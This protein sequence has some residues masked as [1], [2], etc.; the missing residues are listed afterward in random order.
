VSALRQSDLDAALGFLREAEDVTGPTAFP[1]ELLERLEELVPADVVHFC[2]LDRVRQRGI[3]DTFGAGAGSF[4]EVEKADPGWYWRVR[5]EHPT[6]WHQEQ[7]GDFSARKVSDFVTLRELRRREIY[8]NRFRYWPFELTVGLPAPPWHT[9]VFLFH[10]VRHDFR[11]RE[12]ELLELLR[13][14]LVHLWESAKVRRTADAL[15]AGAEVQGELVVFDSGHAIEFATTTA[16]RLLGEYFDGARGARLPPAVEDWLRDE[17]RPR[18]PLL[19]G[20]GQRRLV[21]GRLGGDMSALVL[22]EEAVT[23]AKPLSFREWQVVEL[24]EEG[25]SNA[26]IAAVLWISP[27]TVRT[28]LENIYAKLGV[29]SRTAAVARARDL[30]RAQSA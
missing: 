29:R 18:G 27:A 6:C 4:D 21:I 17:P 30:K 11:R 10:R 1:L 9:K 25:L 26:E 19:V 5:H 12:V 3:S 8:Q 13:P 16:R 28:H 14:H 24:V 2:E 15:A 23:G 22:T 20:R 7:T